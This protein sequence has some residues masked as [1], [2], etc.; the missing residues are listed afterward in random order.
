MNSLLPML[1]LVVL[2]C[3]MCL[4]VIFLLRQI[5]K[6]KN[7]ESDFDKL[8]KKIKSKSATSQDYYSI[9][10]IYLSKKLFDQAIVNFSQA[11]KIWDMS[12]P[13]SLANLYNTIGFTYFETG[14]FDISI[15]YYKQAISLIPKYIIALNNLAHSYEKNNMITEAIQTYNKVLIYDKTNPIA[16][17]KIKFLSSKIRLIRDDRI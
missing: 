11:L 12:D 10:V 15:Y 14:Q 2:I 6:R 4:L 7:V 16:F 17:N 8:Q 9:G 5:L 1:Y 3:S 13:T